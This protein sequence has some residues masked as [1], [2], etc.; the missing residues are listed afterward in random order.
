[1]MARWMTRWNPRVGCVSTSSVPA[2][3]GVLSL[4]KLDSDL[5]RSS[6]LA[7]HARS[8]SAALGLSSRASNRCSTVMNSW[9]C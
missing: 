3:C 1:M 2:T 5:R 6:M 8:T 7:L 9:R 4:M